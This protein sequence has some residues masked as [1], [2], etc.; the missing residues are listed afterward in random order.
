MSERVLTAFSLG[1]IYPHHRD[2]ALMWTDK[3]CVLGGVSTLTLAGRSRTKPGPV[4]ALGIV[5][6]ITVQW[7]FPQ[8]WA[9][10][11]FMVKSTLSQKLEGIFTHISQ[12]LSVQLFS[13]WSSAL[14]ILFMLVFLKDKLSSTQKDC[15]ALGL[16]SFW[17]CPETS[18][19]LEYS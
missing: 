16:S 18:S 6:L 10:P 11:S 5:L 4:W 14:Q 15:W 13:L 3:Y 1:L 12:A 9:V 2:N 17:H 19:T 8:P 7:F